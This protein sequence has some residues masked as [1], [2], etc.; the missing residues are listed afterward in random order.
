VKYALIEQYRNEFRL[1]AMCRILGVSR[2]SFYAAS[3]RLPSRRSTEDL[4]LRE[5]IVNLHNEHRGALGGVKTWRLLNEKGIVCGKHRVARLRKLD[6]IEARRKARFRVMRTYQKTEPPAPN[7]VN[8]AFTVS[9]PNKVWVGDM[10]AVRTR[11]GW[12]HLAVLMDLFARRVVG[13]SMDSAQTANLAIAALK[14]GLAQR[15]PGAGMICH[16][17]QGSTYSASS[18]REVMEQHSLRPSM[19]RKGNCH[20]NAV[21]ES[22][23]SNL[24]NEITH[25]T[26]YETRAEARAAISDYIE[27]YYNTQRPHQTLGYH[28]PAAVEARYKV[29]N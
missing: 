5:Q 15:K 19:S 3:S 28:T 1:I 18:Y 10:T 22:F 7:L 16:T 14:M 27:A 20:D 25:H 2:S 8:R 21:A 9:A 17:D 13:W 24:K 11:E 26:I 23:F 6:G 4:A 12:L 29:L